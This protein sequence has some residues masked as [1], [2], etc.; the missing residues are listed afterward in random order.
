[1]P[2]HPHRVIGWA[3]AALFVPA[4]AVDL[5]ELRFA[6]QRDG[7]CLDASIPDRGGDAGVLE[8]A[9]EPYEAGIEDGSVCYASWCTHLTTAELEA[10]TRDRPLIDLERERDDRYTVVFDP[11]GEGGIYEYLASAPYEALEP[12]LLATAGARF[13]RLEPFEV[14]IPG[15]WE[16]RYLA[17]LI[18]DHHG[19]YFWTH[20]EPNGIEDKVHPVGAD[21]GWPITRLSRWDRE[22]GSR[23]AFVGIRPVENDFLHLRSTD[24]FLDAGA[25][26]LARCMERGAIPLDIT[27]GVPPLYEDVNAVLASR[28]R[29][30][31]QY[32]IDHRVNAE[33][34]ERLAAE[35]GATLLN[36]ETYQTLEGRRYTAI[37][38]GPTPLTSTPAPSLEELVEGFDGRAGYLVRQVR[39]STL[40]SA[41]ADET[42]EADGS[43]ASLIALHAARELEA[44]RVR[45][46]TLH[47]PY[48]RVFALCPSTTTTATSLNTALHATMRNSDN[49]YGR[50]LF[51][52]FGREALDATRLE[53]GMHHTELL[54]PIGCE[55]NV[56]TLADLARLNETIVETQLA[57]VKQYMSGATD[58]RETLGARLR[59]V[60]LEE[61]A[62]MT[63]TSTQTSEFLRCAELRYKGGR[64]GGDGSVFNGSISGW[65]SAP[66][67]CAARCA[68]RF[69]RYV[70]AAF[71]EGGL[72]RCDSE[73]RYWQLR[74]E[75]LR[76]IVRRALQTFARNCR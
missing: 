32:W 76:P 12:R 11:T 73:T 28:K 38:R 68:S 53:A 60:V 46:D 67:D 24:F 37:M 51:E 49:A 1:M 4:C 8:D 50:G 25:D 9:S 47:L 59:D 19:W 16:T 62:S 61:G 65:L 54:G 13:E 7:V 64:D 52:F 40:A 43:I 20:Q 30:D 31:P 74:V 6:C 27:A 23:F 39:G 22:V 72:S 58:D 70:F 21:E 18:A 2:V 17:L 14:R 55:P 29:G 44:R 63:L 45:T 69:D 35:R 41:R 56:T 75:L 33:T 66:L 36:V 48:A 15:G 71:I 3:T 10:R 42:F 26:E 34:V 57:R 5:S